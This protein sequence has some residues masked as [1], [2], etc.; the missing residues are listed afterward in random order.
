MINTPLTRPEVVVLIGVVT[1]PAIRPPTHHEKKNKRK[2]RQMGGANSTRDSYWCA[3]LI[4]V[5]GRSLRGLATA[6]GPEAAEQQAR[7]GRLSRCVQTHTHTLSI[8]CFIL[9]SLFSL[10][11]SRGLSVSKEDRVCDK[12]A[13]MLVPAGR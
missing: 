2:K 6:G 8:F 13:R 7:E 3:C 10:A 11:L 5:E 4:A 9:N 12:E 1:R